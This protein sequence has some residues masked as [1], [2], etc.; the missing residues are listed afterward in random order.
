MRCPAKLLTAHEWEIVGWW[1]Q[2]RK[3][4]AI[5]AV[6]LLDEPAWLLDAFA[7]MDAAA[8]EIEMERRERAET[9]GSGTMGDAPLP[10]GFRGSPNAPRPSTGPM[11]NKGKG[12]RRRRG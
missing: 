3:G 2:H 12:K 9:P 5:T 1:L 8:A 4:R 6:V 11:S 7:V 10:E